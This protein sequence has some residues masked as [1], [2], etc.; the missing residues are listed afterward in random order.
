M[1]LKCICTPH[2]EVKAS[3]YPLDVEYVVKEHDYI[4]SNGIFELV[5]R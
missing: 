5:L 1:P 2:F 4:L 3:S